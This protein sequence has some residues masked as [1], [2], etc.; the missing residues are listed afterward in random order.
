MSTF[1]TVNAN[2]D[3]DYLCRLSIFKNI[4]DFQEVKIVSKRFNSIEECSQTIDLLLTHICNELNSQIEESPFQILT[5][6][7]DD[8]EGVTEIGSLSD[9]GEGEL[10]RYYLT[11]TSKTDENGTLITKFVISMF[12]FNN[13]KEQ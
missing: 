1:F 4:L 2:I 11:N 7:L 12:N 3:D 13:K 9:W 8:E 5:S 6:T 10:I